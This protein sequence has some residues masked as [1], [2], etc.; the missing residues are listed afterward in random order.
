[1]NLATIIKFT[2]A[3]LF[4]NLKLHRR[5]KLQRNIKMGSRMNIRHFISVDSNH[6]LTEIIIICAEV[7]RLLLLHGFD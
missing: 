3:D 4:V 6:E 1:M 7:C 5:V 2:P